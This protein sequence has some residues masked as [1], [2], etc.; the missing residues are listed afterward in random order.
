MTQV[1]FHQNRVQQLMQHL[2]ASALGSAVFARTLHYADRFLMNMTGDRVS[3]PGVLT[4]LPVVV[5]T[6]LGAKSGERRTLP[7]IGIPDGDDIL[8]VA[9]NWGQAHNPGWYYNLRAHP[10]ATVESGGQASKYH[11]QEVTDPQEYQ[12][13]WQ[14]AVDVYLGY[15]EYR[16]RAS[17]RKIPLVLLIPAT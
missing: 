1:T 5:L 13:L 2:P 10:E 12:R 7:V 17:H 4:G 6:T 15:A 16:K 9:S 11:A 3:I 14:R 8:L